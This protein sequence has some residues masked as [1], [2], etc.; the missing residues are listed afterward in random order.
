MADSKRGS[1][2]N[3]AQDERAFTE[4]PSGVWVGTDAG[5]EKKIITRD[6]EARE[7]LI[8]ELQAIDEE[9]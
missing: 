3:K 6:R 2:S 8:E 7:E 5:G 9:A 4:P 1:H